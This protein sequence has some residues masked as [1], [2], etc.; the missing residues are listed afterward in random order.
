MEIINEVTLRRL[1][2]NSDI[3]EYCVTDNVYVTPLAK[4]FLSDRGIKLKIVPLSPQMTVDIKQ[5]QGFKYII[6]ENMQGTNE[7]PEHMTHIRAN[8]L[9]DKTHPR[10]IFRGKLDSLIAQII[11]LQ[12]IAHSYNETKLVNELDEL[13]EY[14]RLILAAEVK[15]SPLENKNLLGLSPDKLR[16]V[17]HNVKSEI[18]INHPIINYKMGQIPITLNCLRT[19]IRECELCAVQAF[20]TNQGFTRD[21]ITKALNR[22]SS[23]V[24]IM[25]CR[26]LVCK[27]YKSE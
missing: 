9:V 14:T 22:M 4:E 6:A 19:K 12:V 2:L 26:F 1:L 10:I 18:G 16:Y 21:D 13:L 23:A 20:H 3:K 15:E 7:K 11:N 27:G 25:L 5:N 8:L 17:S 24:Y